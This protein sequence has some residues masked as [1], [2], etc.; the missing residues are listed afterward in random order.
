MVTY[1]QCLYSQILS[2]AYIHSLFQNWHTNPFYTYVRIF[3][4]FITQYELEV[5]EKLKLNE[6]Q[7]LHEVTSCILIAFFK[8]NVISPQYKFKK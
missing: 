1:P 3:V 4:L 7:T 2:G 5:Q 8:K 6:K